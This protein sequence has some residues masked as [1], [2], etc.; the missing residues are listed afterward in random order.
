M[1][2]LVVGSG[3]REHALAWA[4][5]QE[6]R[7]TTPFC[8]PGNPGIASVATCIP[9]SPLDFDTLAGEATRRGIALTIVGP[10]APLAAGFVDAFAVRGLRAF[11]PTRDA[12]AIESS[13]IFMKSLCRRYEIPT[14]EARTFDDVVP[15]LEYV[16]RA[17]RPLVI[18]AD[19]LA[20]GKGVVMARSADEAAAAVEE[21]MTGRRF[22]DA[23]ARVVVEEW[24]EGR[25]VSVFGLS[26]GVHVVPLLP[27]R[28]YKR[29]LDGDRGPNTGS[30][31][32]YAPADSWACGASQSAPATM[33]SKPEPA[34]DD[35]MLGRITDEILEPAIWA[36]A[37]EGR[38]YRGVLFAGLMLTAAGPRVLEFN[39]RFGDPE[40]QLLMPLL[41]SGLRDAA[42]AA[43]AGRV[44]RWAPRW[45]P[46]YTLC[47]TLCASG[48]PE[49]PRS[50]MPIDGIEAAQALPGVLVF[51]AGT[52]MRD[53]RLV[54][55]GGR[56]LNVVAMGQTLEDARDRA[57]R[58][59]ALI[60][61]EGKTLRRDIGSDEIVPHDVAHDVREVT[62]A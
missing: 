42:E 6:D 1:S 4:L 8:A 5:A 58:A 60:N 14:A 35:A 7:T 20:A 54:V 30:M 9:C 18:K 48:Y 41:A 46:G 32:G 52:A 10:E 25:E 39:A 3:G 12:A 37:Q 62:Q 13:K 33:S 55:S 19:G 15:A 29:L 34:V 44:D 11:G 16:R 56:V 28:D 31:G 21:M 17:G 51:H 27:A 38:P 23:G 49:R 40:A 45:R 2:V 47:V 43:L 50:G 53:G 24:L 57:Y 59:A 36:M 26:D 61:F 22:G